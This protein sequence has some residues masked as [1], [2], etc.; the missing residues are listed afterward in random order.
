MEQTPPD[1][2]VLRLVGPHCGEHWGPFLAGYL[3]LFAWRLL[4]RVGNMAGWYWRRP[5]V[6][7]RREARLAKAIAKNR[8]A[9]LAKA[10]K[11]VPLAFPE[12][13]RKGEATP[14]PACASPG[15]GH[16]WPRGN[17]IST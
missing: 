3:V 6:R 9:R 12:E 13:E 8:A 1:R 11:P 14:A 7:A 10:A 16:T 2:R 15:E 5:A 17:A 4:T